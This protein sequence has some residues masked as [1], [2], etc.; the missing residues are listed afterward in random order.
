MFIL[1]YE[2]QKLNHKFHEFYIYQDKI[3]RETDLREQHYDR[4]LELYINQ[5]LNR[6]KMDKYR[7]IYHQF[8]KS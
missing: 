1:G 6:I 2:N 8:V 5:E 3:L 7:Q 4:V